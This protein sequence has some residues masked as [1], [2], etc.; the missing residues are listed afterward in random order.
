MHYSSTEVA[1]GAAHG[2]LYRQ[3]VFMQVVLKIG[4]TVYEK[5]YFHLNVLSYNM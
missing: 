1:H 5:T 4:F 2:G 3:V